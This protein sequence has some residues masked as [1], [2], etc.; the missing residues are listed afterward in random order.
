V[1][2][3]LPTSCYAKGTTRFLYAN[4]IHIFEY[5]GFAM[6]LR[7]RVREAVASLAAE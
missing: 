1:T 6:T 2:G 3:T 5:R 7:D 4:Q